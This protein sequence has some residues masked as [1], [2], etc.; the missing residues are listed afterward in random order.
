MPIIHPTAIVSSKAKISDNAEIGPYAFIDKD[1][2]V[3]AGVKIMHQAYVTGRTEIGEGTVIYNGAIIG[4][5]PQMKT[6]KSEEGCLRIGK[7]NVIREYVT[8]HRSTGKDKCTTLGD[9]NFLMAFSHAGHDCN[10]GSNVIIAN[11]TLLAGHVTVEDNVFISAHVGIQQFSRIG[12]LAMIGGHARIT[13]DVPPY[14]LCKGDSLIWSLNVIGIRRA[15]FTPVVLNEIK[16]AFKVLYMSDLN[17]AHALERLRLTAHS[18][19]V[20]HLIDFVANSKRGISQH[21]SRKSFGRLKLAFLRID[22]TSNV[23]TLFLKAK[24]GL[25]Y[26]RS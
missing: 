8:I 6:Q 24:K 14:M 12:R 2:S 25:Q 23:Y 22:N 13:Q 10:I 1:V 21:K 26:E 20:K 15:G 18:D 11:G 9:D 16:N 7:R 5:P 19:E 17:T 4:L 3:S